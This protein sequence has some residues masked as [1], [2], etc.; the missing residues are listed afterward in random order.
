M[1]VVCLLLGQA[2]GYAQV[3]VGDAV[4]PGD[5]AAARAMLERAT[6]KALTLEPGEFEVLEPAK[7]LTGPLLWLSSHEAVLQRIDVAAQQPLGLWMKRRGEPTARLHQ[8]PAKPMA[9]VILIGAKAGNGQLTVIRNG[10]GTG[11]PVVVETLV[12]TVGSPG[13]P[14]PPPEDELTRAL[15]AAWQQDVAVGVGDKKW[16]IAL[17]GIYETAS[18]NPLEAVKT[19]GDLDQLLHTARQAAGIPP[20]EQAL[21][22]LRQRLRTE[23]LTQ[24]K[25]PE[26]GA[27]QPINSDGKQRARQLFARIAQALEVISR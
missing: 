24:L 8:F 10:T 1:V 7:N 17:A 18:Q 9:W 3:I 15:R 14:P 2:C 27:S 25:V 19:A 21:T 5:I 12:V 22:Q 23:M 20:V 26:D 13:P 4:P 16:L 11:P 6:P